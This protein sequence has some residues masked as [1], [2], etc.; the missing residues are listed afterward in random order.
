M[1]NTSLVT[2]SNAEGIFGKGSPLGAGGFHKSKIKT[3][4]HIQFPPSTN[5]QNT[6]RSYN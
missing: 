2:F 3:P 6:L 1:V 5:F 4:K